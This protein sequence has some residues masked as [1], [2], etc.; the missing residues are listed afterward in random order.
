MICTMKTL[1]E[2]LGGR[3]GIAMLLRHFYADVRQHA[4]LGPIFDAHVHDWP[5]H[6]AKIAEFWAL[7]T[8][9][10]STYAGGLGAVHLRL[11]IEPQHFD[12]WL[13][14]WDFNCQRRLPPAEAR[15]APSDFKPC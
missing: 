11:G 2:R 1:Y 5:A 7:Q 14:L 15:A 8:G 13:G 6:L 4:V 12:H 9:G 10:P 3:G